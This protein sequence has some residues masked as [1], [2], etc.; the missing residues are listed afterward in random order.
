MTSLLESQ[1]C[2]LQFV[3]NA[4]EDQQ[5]LPTS[6]L[7]VDLRRLIL[8]LCLFF[9][10]LALGNS[11]HAAY[12]VQHG[13]LLAH[14]LDT[15]RAYAEKLAHTTDSFLVASAQVLEAAALDVTESQLELVA[16]R[17]ELD[18]LSSVTDAFSA[19]IVVD[20]SGKVIA[21]K[22]NNAFFNS[23][24]E[25]PRASELLNARQT[26]AISG[27]FKGP[28]GSWMTLIAHPVFSS[29]GGYAGF[30][31]GTVLLQSGSALQNTLGKLD[32]QEGTYFYIVDEKGTV[33]YHPAQD[34]IGSR[35][36]DIRSVP[37]MLRG[38]AGTQHSS[39][40]D[41]DGQVV[42]YA[43]IPFVN[44]GV[45]AQ[46]P[47]KLALS[48]IDEMFL[49]TF[50]YSLPLFIIS[51]LAIWWLSRFIAYPLRELA[52][53][54]GN[55]DNR[56]NFLR[57]RFIKGWYTEA[58]MI[59]EGLMHSFSAVGS[60]MR[61]LSLEGRTDPLT[62]VVNRRGLDTAIEEMN[63]TVQS[64]AVVMI[65]VDHFKAVNDE[66]GHAV[67][68][69]VLKAITALITAEARKED[70][71]ARMGGEEF[72]VLLPGTRPDPARRFAE[73]LRSTIEQ[74]RFDSVGSVTISLGVACCPGN[75]EDLHSTLAMADAALYRAKATGR[76]RVHLA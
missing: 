21:A 51:L 17:K 31:G 5:K 49:R 3:I 48:N 38:K 74:T 13:L 76:N 59:R 40:I 1:S 6:L 63:E 12:K 41:L 44:W 7:R 22:P 37:T 56:A 33:V 4:Q 8:W 64:V 25:A 62:G 27:P 70:V 66:F 15:N 39:A 73:R 46:R 50:Y 75:A 61:K 32:Y 45:V 14:G 42:S 60:R 16:I 72:V 2:W 9:V 55:L 68:D 23:L 30:V 26:T 36:K 11:L 19:L 20:I 54:A 35:S 58:A 18:Q 28:R 24:S 52:E 34:L 67:G 29:E 43:S 47:T 69:D 53:V 10:V 65:D 57:I 71:V